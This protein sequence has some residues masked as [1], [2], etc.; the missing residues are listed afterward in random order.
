VLLGTLFGV[1][2]TGVFV[3]RGVF[4]KASI[5]EPYAEPALESMVS[6]RLLAWS[7]AF[8]VLDAL[9]LA[10]G[11]LFFVVLIRTVVRHAWIAVVA[12]SLLAAPIAPGGASSIAGLAWAFVTAVIA[13]ATVMRVGLLAGAVAIICMRLLTYVALTANPASWYFGS[14]VIVLLLV[15]AA[16]AYGFI[17]SLAGK[18]AFGTKS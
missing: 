14:T 6:S 12:L 3:A 17:V 7:V 18:P 16:A 10:L 5:A 15:L 9:Q 11:A 8:A 1:L 13:V 4:A 2:A